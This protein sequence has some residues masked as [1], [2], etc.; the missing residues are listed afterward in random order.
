MAVIRVPFTGPSYSPRSVAV[1]TQT[2]INL[3]PEEIE[4]PSEK[5]KDSAVMYGSPGTLSF[6]NMASI[7]A[8]FTNIRGIWSG[9]GRLFVA[10][11]TKYCEVNTTTGAGTNVRTI[12]NS[13]VNGL[14]NAP[15]QFFSN[16]NQLMIVSGGTAYIDNGAGPIAIT[17][18]ANSGNVNT[19]DSG[20]VYYVYWNSGDPFYAAM[21]GAAIT[22]NA[23][24]YTVAT[25]INEYAVTLTGTAGNQTGVSY[26]AAAPSALSILTGAYLDGYYALG[27]SPSRQYNISALNNKTGPVW[28]GL[29]YSTKNSYPDNLNCVLSN[30][31]LFL[32][33]QDSTDVHRNT[34]GTFPFSK[35]DGASFKVGAASPWAPIAINSRVFFIGVSSQG[36]CV[37]YVLDGYTPHQHARGG[38]PVESG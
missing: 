25:F 27:R 22:I 23:V 18:G 6:K 33:G 7:D 31:D 17:L 10:G 37:A 1:G 20:G 36:A 2:T 5:M 34:G 38:V 15:A 16:G 19:V 28:S 14:A 29:D 9:A 11:G 35:M 3:Y 13:S 26:S 4:N 32:F 21:V 8:G 24:A 30:D 12:S